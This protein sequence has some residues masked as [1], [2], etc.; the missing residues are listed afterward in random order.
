MR[1]KKET[2]LKTDWKQN[3]PSVY[4]E[5]IPA[6]ERLMML[7]E[8]LKEHPDSKAD[9]RR[10]RLFEM[11][12]G[13]GRKKADRFMYA[14]LMLKQKGTGSVNF[15]NRRRLRQEIAEQFAVFGIPDEAAYEETRLEWEQFARTVISTNAD[16]RGYSS[17]LL[18]LVGISDRNVILKISE[19]I[20]TITKTVPEMAGLEKE[21]AAFRECF[22]QIFIAS[23]TDGEKY[24]LV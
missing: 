23:I 12:Y 8:I 24:W 11:R 19:E 5:T 1:L 20:R 7:K 3:W 9:Q 14:W 4:Y 15:A 6:E 17:I 13:K 2:I 10:M 18:G 22:H 16:D 21:T